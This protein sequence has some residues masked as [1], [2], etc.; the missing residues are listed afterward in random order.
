MKSALKI[1]LNHNLT[2]SLSD[3]KVNADDASKIHLSLTIAL[4]L[5]NVHFL[6]SHTVA[7]MSSPGLCLYMALSLHY[8]LLATFSWMTLEGF[9]LYLL[10]IKVFNIYIR[11]YL[12]KLSVVGWGEW[13]ELG[14]CAAAP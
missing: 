11:R 10:L 4:I 2:S 5:L 12:L 8:S 14:I 1:S 6:P 7:E 3:R 9:H 13:P